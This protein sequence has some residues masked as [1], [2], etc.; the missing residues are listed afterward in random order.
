M[1]TIEL[2]SKNTLLEILK[3][4]NFVRM[5]LFRKSFSY[6]QHFPFNTSDRLPPNSE[7]EL[8][9]A[10]SLL[11]KLDVPFRVTDGTALGLIREGKFIQHDN[12]LDLDILPRQGQEERTFKAIQRAFEQ[13]G[14]RVGR[15]VRYCSIPQQLIV[16][17]DRSVLVDLL[18]WQLDHGV[19]RNYSEEG[20]V[21]I[22]E[23]KFFR[24]LSEYNYAWG[25][26]PMPRDIDE[27]LTC[28]Y[29]KSWRTPKTYKGDW[30]DD[31]YD[32]EPIIDE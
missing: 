21:R 29:G 19:V 5:R 28:R 16:Y 18:F 6:Y 22:Q 30:K 32:I 1:K 31:C 8:I 4:I 2:F 20:F 13:N 23:E 25:S 14:Y 7:L 12:D 24:E 11:R 26:I 9:E 15:I 3:Y 17:N 10:C 27:W